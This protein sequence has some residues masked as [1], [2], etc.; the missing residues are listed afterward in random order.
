MIKDRRRRARRNTPH[1]LNVIEADTGK[2]LGRLVNITGHGLMIVTRSQLSPDREF[3]LRLV[4]PRA[5][6]GKDEMV[7][8]AVSVYCREDTNPDFYRVGFKFRKISADDTVL[9]EDIMHTFHLVG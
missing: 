4:F 9:L 3:R 6:H 8:T 7:I 1:Y 2:S 5:I